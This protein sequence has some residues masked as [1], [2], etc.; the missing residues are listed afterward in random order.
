MTHSY[1]GLKHITDKL[2]KSVWDAHEYGPNTPMARARAGMEDN[3]P[4]ADRSHEPQAA[5]NGAAKPQVHPS[6]SSMEQYGKRRVRWCGA[7]E[8]GNS[9]QPYPA[10]GPH[11]TVSIQWNRNRRDE[12]ELQSPPSLNIYIH[13]LGVPPRASFSLTVPFYGFPVRPCCT[14]PSES[15]SLPGSSSATRYR[16][17]PVENRVVRVARG[18][19]EG[20]KTEG[21]CGERQE[22]FDAHCA[23][24]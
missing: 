4:R 8:P 19:T 20:M 11:P 3:E 22:R 13:T 14:H 10:C 15:L 16:G 12:D 23:G 6:S 17:R 21:E 24:S 5:G 18:L 7:A 9:S 2:Y 1:I